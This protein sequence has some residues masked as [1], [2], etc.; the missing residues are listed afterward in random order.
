MNVDACE[1]AR[2]ALSFFS[3]F[4]PRPVTLLGEAAEMWELLHVSP[5]RLPAS[6]GAKFFLLRQHSGK[7]RKKKGCPA[8]PVP[9]RRVGKCEWWLCLDRCDVIFLAFLT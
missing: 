7:G 1:L 8:V 5:Q 6:A 3:F 2:R 4:P 9:M